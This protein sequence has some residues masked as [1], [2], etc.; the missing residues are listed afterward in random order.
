[1]VDYISY[2]PKMLW[3]YI[4]KGIVQVIKIVMYPV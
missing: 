2:I 3:D 1:M 4:T